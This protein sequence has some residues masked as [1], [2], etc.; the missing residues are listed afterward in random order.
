[1]AHTPLTSVE[2]ARRRAQRR[3]PGSVYAF[4]DGGNEARVTVRANVDAFSDIG[5]RPHVASD[6]APRDLRT[7]VLGR[8]IS[9]PLITTPAGFIRIAHRDG[10]LGVARAA[11]AAGIPTGVSILASEPIESITAVNPDTWFQLYLIGGREG[12]AAAI[13][14]ARAAGVR[15]LMVTVD[16][17]AGTGGS[18]ARRAAMPPGR[19]SAGA[20]LRYAPEIATHPRWAASFLRGGLDLIAPNA[21]GRDGKPMTIAEGSAALREHPPTWADIAFIREQ[22]DGPLVVKGIVTGDDA[23]RAADLGVDAV[24][25]SNH[26]GNGLDGAPA[27]I[28]ALPEVVSAVGDRIDVLMD[29]GVRRGG[30]VVKAVALGARAVL[31]GRPYIWAMAAGGEQGVTE[32]LA[33]FRKGISG[34]LTLLDCPGVADLDPRVLDLSRFRATNG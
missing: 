10:E 8:E 31:I 25:V 28:R 16:L 30:D 1:M 3:L 17:A 23:R 26:G 18:D 15:V 6:L 13:A 29:G 34:T 14:R 11:A 22:W 21:P 32:I 5:F 2:Q 7:T 19:V 24:S 12:T 4:I 27:T 33:A 20:A 9:M